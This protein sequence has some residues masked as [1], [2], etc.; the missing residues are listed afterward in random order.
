MRAVKTGEFGYLAGVS[1]FSLATKIKKYFG[2]II[3]NIIFVLRLKNMKKV[4]QI[5]RSEIHKNERSHDVCIVQQSNV[6]KGVKLKM[7]YESY[8][9]VE[10]FTGEL[11]VNGKWEHHFS[12]LDLGVESERSSYIWD[13]SKRLKRAEDLISRGINYFITLQ[14]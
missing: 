3:N 2:Y 5:Y 11:F 9:A 6:V 13:N 7:T 1:E 8:N 4:K 12:M 14:E 10:R